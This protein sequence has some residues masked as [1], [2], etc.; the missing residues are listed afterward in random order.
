[1][2][3]KRFS[4]LHSHG[5]LKTD[6]IR[7]VVR[8]QHA[9]DAAATHHGQQ[10]W[11]QALLQQMQLAHSRSPSPAYGGCEAL[12]PV[13]DVVYDGL[14]DIFYSKVLHVT[15]PPNVYMHNSAKYRV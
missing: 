11:Q 13:L 14:D 6:A 7:V 10:P 2:N 3:A 5:L 8:A 1:M 12:E 4:S 15:D 9:G